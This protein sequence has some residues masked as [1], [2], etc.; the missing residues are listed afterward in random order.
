MDKYYEL[1]QE[2]REEYFALLNKEAKPWYKIGTTIS[3]EKGE[4][5]DI[6]KLYVGDELVKERNINE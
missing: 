6:L 3:N 1:E 5:T 2:R 4:T